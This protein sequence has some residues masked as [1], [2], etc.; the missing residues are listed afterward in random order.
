MLQDCVPV[1]LPLLRAQLDHRSAAAGSNGGNDVADRGATAVVVGRYDHLRRS[2]SSADELVQGRCRALSK[3]AIDG[4]PSGTWFAVLEVG[5][6]ECVNV[7]FGD[8][9]AGVGDMRDE[10]EDPLLGALLNSFHAGPRIC[11][12]Q[13][14]PSPFRCLPQDVP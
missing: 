7:A 10:N 5:L 13:M 2:S 4:K 9:D 1:L 3:A 14:R 11:Q 12:P 8:A 6:A